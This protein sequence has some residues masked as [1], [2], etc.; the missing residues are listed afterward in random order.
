MAGT[1][2]KKPEGGREPPL[3]LQSPEDQLVEIARAEAVLN[4]RDPRLAEGVVRAQFVHQDTEASRQQRATAVQLAAE[5]GK[6]GRRNKR[7]RIAVTAVVVVLAAVPV[8]RA[9]LAENSRADALYARLE[10][11][12]EPAAQLGFRQAKRW[13]E[14]P[15]AGVTFQVP[16]DTC[17]SLVAVREDGTEPLALEIER[18]NATKITAPGGVI[19][20]SCE[21]DTVTVRLPDA[22]GARRALGYLAA[23]MGT[24]GGIEVLLTRPTGTYRLVADALAKECADAGFSAWAEVAGQ[25]DIDPLEASRPGPTTDLVGDGFEPVG[26]FPSGRPYAVI[27]ARQGRCYVAAPESGRSEIAL[28]AADGTRLVAKAN[29]A[30]VWCSH[31]ADA[32]FSLWRAENEKG[33]AAVAVLGALA[34]RAGGITGVRAAARRHGARD[35]QS[36]LLPDELSR[37]ARATLAASGVPAASVQEADATGLPGKPE[38]SVVA[39]SLRDRMSML[40]EVSPVVATA[41]LPELDA[42]QLLRTFLCAETRAQVWHPAGD[43]RQQGAAEGVRPYWLGLFGGVAD[44]GALRASAA[45]MLFAQRMTLLGYE[46]TTSDGIKDLPEGAVVSGRAGKGDVIAVGIT[47]AKPWLTPLTDGPRWSLEGPL[48]VVQIPV[49]STKTLRGEVRLAADAKDRRVVVWRR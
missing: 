48:R 42:G 19:W 15:A 23:T 36:A 27:R 24:V 18:Q 43:A 14:V 21:G 31:A 5:K 34:D 6:R 4:R 30:V 20:C 37:D 46:P 45:L 8:T 26:L 35:V 17:A 39:F 7:I 49:G 33:S 38:N 47:K 3:D 12:G 16:R 41:C 25:G 28:R 40:P 11:L 2:P 44:E 32:V 22:G 13:L 29:G 10:A 1:V 9:L